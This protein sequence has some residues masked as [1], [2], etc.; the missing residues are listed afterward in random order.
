MSILWPS[1]KIKGEKTKK[2][3]KTLRRNVKIE[4][5]EPHSG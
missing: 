1:R 3:E 4:P 5:H 2:T